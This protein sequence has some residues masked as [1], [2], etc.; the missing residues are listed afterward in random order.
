MVPSKRNKDA[1]KSYIYNLEV[2]SDIYTTHRDN[3]THI[4]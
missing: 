4:L 1:L 3:P 2:S